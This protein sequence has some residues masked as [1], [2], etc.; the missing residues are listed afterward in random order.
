MKNRI[1]GAVVAAG[2]CLVARDAA[3]ISFSGNTVQVTSADV[4]QSF[5]LSFNSCFSDVS[6]G[7]VDCIGDGGFAGIAASAT[8]RLDSFDVANNNT[9][10]LTVWLR[11]DTVSPNSS[12]ISVFGFATSPDVNVGLSDANG[13]YND[14]NDGSFPQSV[15]GSNIEVCALNEQ[16]NNCNN[17][18]GGLTNGQLG[19]FTLQLV[20]GD[21]NNTAGLTFSDFAVRYQSVTIPG[22]FASQQGSGIGVSTPR[23]PR[24]G[25][26]GVPIPEPATLA[27]LG[28]GLLGAGAAR[29]RLK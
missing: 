9:A 26:P 21:L 3:A 23:P 24:P 7:S 22:T 5:A 8:L 4:G 14:L 12:R 1:A 20:F 18:S 16:N 27:L 15:P 6:G 25:D 2:M 17:G 28:V 13:Y 11:N 19:Q 29:R 10:N